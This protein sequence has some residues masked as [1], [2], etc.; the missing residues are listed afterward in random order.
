MQWV[1]VLA[2]KFGLKLWSDNTYYIELVCELYAK[3]YFDYIELY[4]VPDT[5][6]KYAAMWSRL[7]VPFIMHVPHSAHGFNLADPEL[8]RVNSKLFRETQSFAN[9][10]SAPYIIVHAGTLGDRAVIGENLRNLNDKRLLIENKPHKGVHGK[11]CAGVSPEEI[12]NYMDLASIGFCFDVSHAVKYAVTLEK[13]Y[14]DIIEG[15]LALGP[16]VMH[17]GGVNNRTEVDEHLHFSEST[18]DL[19]E[20]VALVRKAHIPFC[21]LETPKDSKTH[22]N[23]FKEEVIFLKQMFN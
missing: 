11:I 6:Q 16:T 3:Q 8:V 2:M 9:C 20:I 4:A 5:Y 18:C 19:K 10:L 13:D 7:G 21:T 15:F 1:K 23:D 14:R 12:K 17:L 22:L